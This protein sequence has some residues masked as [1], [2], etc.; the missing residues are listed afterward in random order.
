M[1]LPF[2][3]KRIDENKSSGNIDFR[4][5]ATHYNLVDI[6]SRGMGTIKLQER[7]LWWNMAQTG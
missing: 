7:K 3:Q 4:Y 5:V 1:L 2:I 6:A